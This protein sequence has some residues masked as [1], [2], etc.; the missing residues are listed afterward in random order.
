VGEQLDLKAAK[1]Y[2]DSMKGKVK[3]IEPE[4]SGVV[5]TLGFAFSEAVINNEVQ[6]AS[7]YHNKLKAVFRR[8]KPK[9]KVFYRPTGFITC[10]ADFFENEMYPKGDKN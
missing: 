7:E 2:G 6:E 9:Y 3:R 10:N 4:I 5:Q 8:L 1:N